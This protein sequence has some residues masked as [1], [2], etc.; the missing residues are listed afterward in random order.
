MSTLG[1]KVSNNLD[2]SKLVG[3]ENVIN[4]L[5]LFINVYQGSYQSRN[6]NKTQVTPSILRDIAAVGSP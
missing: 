2:I 1:V 6:R 4:V 3:R 5:K